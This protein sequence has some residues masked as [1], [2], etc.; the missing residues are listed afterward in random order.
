MN[1]PLHLS[2]LFILTP[3]NYFRLVAVVLIMLVIGLAPE[4]AYAQSSAFDLP[5]VN[6][7]GCAIIRWI[8][9]PLA[10]IVFLL[11]AVSAFVI[12]LFAKMDWTK[13]L[14]AVILYGILQGI[15]GGAFN[16]GVINPPAGCLR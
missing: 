8:S 6:T 4:V 2:H 13:V 15:V 3:E 16:L 5:I 10:I 1:R 12:G 7:I 14:T 11:V 9:G